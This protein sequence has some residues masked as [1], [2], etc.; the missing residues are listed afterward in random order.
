MSPPRGVCTCGCMIAVDGKDDLDRSRGPTS[1]GRQGQVAASD[2]FRRTLDR[3]GTWGDGVGP[4]VRRRLFRNAS[5]L[6]SVNRELR[7]RDHGATWRS[8]RAG[9]LARVGLRHPE[10]DP[11]D[12]Q[13]A[14]DSIRTRNAFLTKSNFA[15][16]SPPSTTSHTLFAARRQPGT[17]RLSSTHSPAITCLPLPP[18]SRLLRP[19]TPSIAHPRRR[20][21]RRSA[22]NRSSHAG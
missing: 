17:I 7:I 11:S 16:L 18:R 14:R 1:A 12:Q 19:V 15:L 8:A 2:D 6:G 9:C 3:C 20:R 5:S 21:R 10:S 22:G 4:A 13:L